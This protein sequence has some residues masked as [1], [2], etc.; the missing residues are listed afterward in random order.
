MNKNIHVA[1]NQSLDNQ[2]TYILTEQGDWHEDEIRFLR[3][4]ITKDMNVFDYGLDHDLYALSA[5]KS[6]SSNGKV[7]YISSNNNHECTQLSIQLNS[8]NDYFE[9]SEDQNV[10]KAN[11]HFDFMRF[12]RNTNHQITHFSDTIKNHLPVIMTEAI[13]NDDSDLI[14]LGQLGYNL[15]RLRPSH[16]FLVPLGDDFLFPEFNKQVFLIPNNKIDALHNSGLL[17]RTLSIPNSIDNSSTAGLDWIAK[18]S[19]VTEQQIELF[20]QIYQP[21]ISENSDKMLNIFNTYALSHDTTLT[22]DERY[23]YL[24]AT[25]SSLK[26]IANINDSPHLLSTYARVSFE[27]GE[28]KPAMDSLT[29]L[30]DKILQNG[31]CPTSLFLLPSEKYENIKQP[32]LISDWMCLQTIEQAFFT[33]YPSEYFDTSGE[34]ESLINSLKQINQKSEAL[35]NMLELACKRQ[36]KL[37]VE[38]NK[39][40]VFSYTNTP[41]YMPPLQNPVTSFKVTVC[42]ATYNRCKL[43]IRTIDSVLSQSYTNFELLICDD[44]STDETER[45]CKSMSKLDNR[46]RYHRNDKNLGMIENYVQMYH[47]IET[48]LFVVCSDD[49]FLFPRHLER[50]VD[51]FYKQPGLGMAFGQTACGN[52]DNT[53]QVSVIPTNLSKDGIVD[54]KQMLL[55]SI[56]GNNICWTSALIRKSA[57]KSMTD[58]GENNLALNFEDVFIKEGDYFFV[59][60]MLVTAPTAFV[61]VPASYFS[62]DGS[63]YSSTQ[64][65]GGWGIEIRLRTI[66]YLHKLYEN[67]FGSD[68][69]EKQKIRE[70][71]EIIKNTLSQAERNLSSTDREKHSNKVNELKSMIEDIEQSTTL[72][73]NTNEDDLA[74][75]IS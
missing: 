19:Y 49:D 61:N 35:N 73:E 51:A 68:D 23:G 29:K 50:T 37:F 18:R 40:D 59:L 30:W 47:K 20:K 26:S 38:E 17:V 21:G 6:V 7:L 46:I 8:F 25:Q 70:M 56:T 42:V 36:N 62:V 66:Y 15:Y 57:V 13:F 24:C 58:Y 43:L 48:E 2:T 71:N 16:N 12:S 64:L 65:G 63:S 1:V 33:Q 27:L 54:P 55:D 39:A 45:Y 9:L 75:F 10:E 22:P 31:F 72:T 41:E 67:N 14:W 3:L 69:I 32:I 52:V 74:K 5:A 60:L 53:S 11:Q 34:L 44:S 28:R 4:L